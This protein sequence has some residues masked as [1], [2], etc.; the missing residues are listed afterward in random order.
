[1]TYFGEKKSENCASDVTLEDE[2]SNL[3]L[4]W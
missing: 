3:V 4:T 1:M 2:I